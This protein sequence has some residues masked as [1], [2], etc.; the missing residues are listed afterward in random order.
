[1]GEFISLTEA[2]ARGLPRYFT[3]K[4]CKHGHISERFVG[5]THCVTCKLARNKK[6]YENN[7]E[8]QQASQRD[9]N[10]R[11]S[12]KRAI[13]SVK[14]RK[15]HPEVSA[16]A[17]RRY[18]A[19]NPHFAKYTR[20][21]SRARGLGCIPKWFGELDELAFTEAIDLF[22]RRTKMTGIA[23]EIDHIVPMKSKWVCGFHTWFNIRVIPQ[24]INRSK[25]NRPELLGPLDWI[26]L[27]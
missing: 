8:Q 18:R 13:A 24:K 14:Y 12:E 11:N 1:M 4:P 7:R 26:P 17:S 6:F 9:Y 22:K 16:A 21:L 20:D 15:A 19:K 3:G 27:I 10:R 25:H 23:W 2:R 5:D